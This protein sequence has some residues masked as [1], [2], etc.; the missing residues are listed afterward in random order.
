MTHG[1]LCADIQQV[2]AEANN[3]RYERRVDLQ[4]RVHDVGFDVSPPTI[5][6]EVQPEPAANQTA[7]QSS[8]R[9]TAKNQGKVILKLVVGVD[10]KVEDVRVLQSLD[11]VLDKKAVE[12]VQQWKFSPGRMKG[13]PVPAQMVVEVVFHLY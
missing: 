12:A 6:Q 1:S 3:R 2:T 4:K 7:P 9:R 10:G 5:I 8:G 13:L 11:V